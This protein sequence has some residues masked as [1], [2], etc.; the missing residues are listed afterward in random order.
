MIIIYLIL[1]ICLLGAVAFKQKNEGLSTFPN[2]ERTNILDS[3]II[4][5]DNQSIDNLKSK[6]DTATGQQYLKELENQFGKYKKIT[7]I[8]TGKSY[9]VPTRDILT[10]GV[11]GTDLEKYPEW[12]EKD[13]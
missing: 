6:W 5:E 2:G 3:I 13:E 9:K 1:I 10:V 7:L 11:K 4:K 12:E 8:T